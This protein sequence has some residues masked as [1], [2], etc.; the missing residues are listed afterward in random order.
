[1]S[2]ITQQ[3]P[4]GAISICS[5]GHVTLQFGRAMIQLSM[6]EFQI[7]L[8]ASAEALLQFEELPD[9]SAGDLMQSLRH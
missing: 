3:I 2:S 9:K 7:F 6:E 5:S 1:M 4:N 8:S